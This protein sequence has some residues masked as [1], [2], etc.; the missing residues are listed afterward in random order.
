MS[1]EIDQ[2]SDLIMNEVD[3]ATLSNEPAPGQ[4]NKPPAPIEA[5]TSDAR[6]PVA[7]MEVDEGEPNRDG[8]TEEDPAD[9]TPEQQDASLPSFEDAGG[10]Q[11][12]DRDDDGVV[13][14]EERDEGEAA[15]DSEIRSKGMLTPSTLEKIKKVKIN[16]IV[17]TDHD[18]GMPD[19]TQSLRKIAVNEALKQY[20]DFKRIHDM[21]VK[22]FTE[23]QK[24]LDPAVADV[25]G[26]LTYMLHA[27]SMSEQ[28]LR[29]KE[30]RVNALVTQGD[31]EVEIVPFRPPAPRVIHPPL[32]RTNRA[33][34]NSSTSK[35][36]NPYIDDEAVED[37]RKDKEERSGR[38][39][40]VREYKSE[41][42]Y[43]SKDDEDAYEDRSTTDSDVDEEGSET[44]S[45]SDDDTPLPGPNAGKEGE[46]V[47]AKD[48]P[49]KQAA[50]EVSP[51]PI[52][53]L[54]IS[55][56]SIFHNGKSVMDVT[57]LIKDI[58]LAESGYIRRLA[59]VLSNH[60]F[61]WGD[62]FQESV[63]GT[64]TC[65]NYHENSQLGQPT[66][67]ALQSVI[68]LMKKMADEK[69]TLKRIQT[70]PRLIQIAETDPY[71]TPES[72]NWNIIDDSTRYP[73]DKRNRVFRAFHSMACRTNDNVVWTKVSDLQNKVHNAHLTMLRILQEAVEHISFNADHAQ[74]EIRTTGEHAVQEGM[75][76]MSQSIAW[77]HQQV[78][79][80]AQQEEESKVKKIHHQGISYLQRKILLVIT[81]VMLVY[82][83]DVYNRELNKFQVVPRTKAEIADRRKELGGSVINQLSETYVRQN[84]ARAVKGLKRNEVA[85]SEVLAKVT[86]NDIVKQASDDT[87]E[88]RRQALQA[89]ACFLMFGTSGLFHCWAWAKEQKMT[90][91][92]VLIHM[93]TV[94]AKRRQEISKDEPHV[95]YQRAW[96][97]LDHHIYSIL[98]KFI[99]SKDRTSFRKKVDWP[100][101][102]A[103]F[104]SEFSPTTLSYIYTL[105][106]CMEMH[107]PL[108]SRTPNGSVAPDF[109]YNRKRSKTAPLLVMEPFRS[110]FNCTEGPITPVTNPSNM[111][112]EKDGTRVSKRNPLKSISQAKKKARSD[113]STN[114]SAHSTSGDVEEHA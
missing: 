68:V 80:K 85:S 12:E 96:S 9:A 94:L 66:D 111:Y 32:K 6:A 81:G 18:D 83:R 4:S 97:R 88:L 42:F 93:S 20:T 25:D 19:S 31:T 107:S 46:V 108:S 104:Q 84:P 99:S 22:A 110:V 11:G 33:Q 38:K 105:D 82:E 98:R 28:S 63:I 55:A 52:D 114:K 58:T 14:S 23:Y 59:K 29:R 90:D 13:D 109:E 17:K 87:Y 2:P 73:W 60:V 78:M 51:D 75:I 48:V 74:I 54:P 15:E 7:T 35:R 5:L 39:K 72:I 53:Y 113:L 67:E 91:A 49:K 34:G 1:T 40:R 37:N 71:L 102:T 89:L 69:E 45:E 47:L 50:R 27:L 62:A 16:K 103:L 92:A 70:C 30:E 86:E 26:E 44:G 21:S 61:D 77:L 56:L 64:I 57:V 3:S 65:W 106:L 8:E 41:E 101:M 79:I 43:Y 10:V 36:K 95:F 76:P 100:A 112:K 24:T